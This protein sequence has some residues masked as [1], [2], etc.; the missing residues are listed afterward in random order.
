MALSDDQV[1]EVEKL[2]D[3]KIRDACQQGGIIHGDEKEHEKKNGIAGMLNSRSDRMMP[4]KFDN[5]MKSSTLF[6]HWAEE[7]KSYLKVIDPQSMVLINVAEKD[8]DTKVNK[9][10]VKLYIQD[11]RAMVDKDKFFK[12]YFENFDADPD[13]MYDNITEIKDEELHTIIMMM[14]SGEAKEMVRNAAPS[15]MEA[16]RTLNYRWNRKTQF[17]ATQIAELIGKI[18]PAKSPDDVYSK[19]NQLERLHLELQKNLGEDVI[20]GKSVKVVYGEAF[21]KADVLRVVNEEFN[22]QLKKEVRN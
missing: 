19:L 1:S 13:D 20:D 18:T 7:L 21:K 4:E 3:D 2:I 16:W 6:R 10:A 5:E 12:K 11:Q 8:T 9:E 15:G 14:V 22:Q 17:G